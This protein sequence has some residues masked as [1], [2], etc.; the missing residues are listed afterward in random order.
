[1]SHAATNWAFKQRGLKPATKIVLLA[2]AD[3][4]NPDMGCF[5]SKRLLA[6]D[7]EM[8]ERAVYDH[9]KILES[10]GL[11]AVDGSG[12]RTAGQYSS[13]RYRL[14]FEDDF[15]HRQN[16]PSA[17]SA[18]GR[19]EHLPSA[20]SADGRRQN[21]PTNPVRDNHVRKETPCKS[22]KGDG[23][24]DEFEVWWSLYPRKVG[25]GQAARAYERKRKIYGWAVLF[26][27]LEAQIA[28]GGL[29]RVEGR[30]D[31]RPH[32]ATWLNG[33]RFNDP[34]PERQKSTLERMQEALDA[35]DHRSEARS[36]GA[37]DHK[38][39]ASLPET[40]LDAAP[41]R[42]ARA[43]NGAGTDHGGGNQLPHFGRRDG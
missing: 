21:L 5:P 11:V 25:K 42:H 43:G 26:S 17:K 20:K 33:D 3:R 31:F 39:P 32:P 6:E 41:A 10:S 27:A 28:S 34:L 16:Q 36:E 15:H 13:N 35:D 38:A 12:C 23:Y 37:Y 1:M 22:P 7:C 14:A 40:I 4:H 30:N 9:I 19:K 8:S 18:V 29:G 24:S 2:L